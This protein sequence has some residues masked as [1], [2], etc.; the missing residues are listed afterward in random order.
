MAVRLRTRWHRSRRSERNREGSNRPKSLDSLSS[1]AA[2]NIW[3]LAKDSFLHMEK[4]GF[5]FAEDRQAIDIIS[6]F[7]IF[8]LHI[9]DRLIYGRMP[10]EERG[11]LVNAIAHHLLETIVSNQVDLLGPGEYQAAL[12]ERLNRRLADYAACSFDDNGPGY[13]FYRYLGQSASEAMQG[14]DAKWV[15]EQV[16]DIEGPAMAEK[17]R[18]VVRDVLGVKDL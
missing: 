2:I 6:E 16:M 11:P 7:S 10:E 9:I 18:P 1:A 14:G 15:L 5:I 3:K 17:M 4:E 13:D 12:V 8:L